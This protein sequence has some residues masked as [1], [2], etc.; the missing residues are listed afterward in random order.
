MVDFDP[1]INPAL[2]IDGKTWGLALLHS[3]PD[4]VSGSSKY[5]CSNVAAS[6]IGGAVYFAHYGDLILAIFETGPAMQ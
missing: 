4:Y 3:S 1:L 2:Y 5:N 6:S